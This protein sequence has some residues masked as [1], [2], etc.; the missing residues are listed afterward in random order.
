M[1]EEKM[2]ICPECKKEKP[3]SEVTEHACGYAAKVDDAVSMEVC[4]NDCEDEHWMDI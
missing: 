1:K 4:C 2:V 3:A